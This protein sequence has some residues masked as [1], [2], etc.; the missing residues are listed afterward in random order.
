MSDAYKIFR[1]LQ[2][3]EKEAQQYKKYEREDL[4][5]EIIN[6]QQENQQLK[7]NNMSMQEE[8]VRTWEKIDLYKE[9]I[10]E[11]IEKIKTCYFKID[12]HSDK[13]NSFSLYLK[14]KDT[15]TGEELLQILDK[16]KGEDN[17]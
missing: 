13:Y 11:V 14:L 7:E 9:V 12:N 3:R 17:G 2:E 15:N 5:D 16:A 8:I 10:E 6:L 1:Q 4:I